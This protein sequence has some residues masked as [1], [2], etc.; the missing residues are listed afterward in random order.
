MNKN[1]KLI[2]FRSEWFGAYGLDKE[3]NFLQAP[4]CECGCGGK[5]SILL[6]TKEELLNFMI[7]M[8][9]ENDCTHCAMFAHALS[10]KM[11]AAVKSRKLDIETNEPV[12]CFM[13]DNTNMKFF[14]NWDK[15]LRFHWYG[16][17]IEIKKG[18]WK[19]IED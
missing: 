8:L 17:I 7:D 11:Y 15:E 16:L 14:K 18:Q 4:E 9:E 3:K 12:L 6:K 2:T 5:C 10:G 13:A 19:I 1:Q